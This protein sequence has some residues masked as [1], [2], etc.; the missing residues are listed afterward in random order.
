MF[1]VAQMFACK[2]SFLRRLRSA[3]YSGVAAF[4]E[5]GGVHSEQAGKERNTGIA[6]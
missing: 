2:I 1:S 3:R 6:Y 4:M 5:G